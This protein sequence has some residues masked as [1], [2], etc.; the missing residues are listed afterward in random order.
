M[1]RQL[2]VALLAAGATVAMAQDPAVHGTGA[3]CLAGDCHNGTG[4]LLRGDG[5]QYTGPWI[6][7][8]FAGG[9]YQVRWAAD[10]SQ[11]H[12]LRIDTEGLALEGTMVR[13]LGDWAKATSTYTG[14]FGRVWNPFIERHMASFATGRYLDTK[15]NTYEGEFQYIP[16]RAYGEHVVTGIFLFQGVRI[17]PVEDEVVAGLFISDPTV[18]GANIAFYRARPDYIAK[19]QQDFAFDKQRSAQDK[20]D[21]AS[22]QA[23]W[24][25]LLNLTMGAAAM[26]G[27]GGR[28]GGFDALGGFGGGLGGFGGAGG[29][30]SSGKRLA[31]NLLGDVLRGAEPAQAA[32][33]RLAGDLQQRALGAPQAAAAL[34]LGGGA[35]ASSQELAQ[36]IGQSLLA[37]PRKL[38]V[39][40]YQR[41][42]Q[43]AAGR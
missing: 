22:R 40:E 43:E 20:A 11:T 25:M 38:T 17:D 4:T 5:N 21:Q 28:G 42:L 34:G 16:S 14:T 37:N 26:S 13:G 24:G 23:A 15:G 39:K 29:G 35:P 31:L 3:R 19:L 7:G 32:A 8:R 33:D 41:L 18:S 12:P 2:I 10:A 27:G 6:G 36:R 30:G 9:T 1:Q